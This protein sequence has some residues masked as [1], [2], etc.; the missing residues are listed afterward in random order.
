[1]FFD[2]LAS[3]TDEMLLIN[4]QHG[5]WLIRLHIPEKIPVL[6]IK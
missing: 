6:I 5:V 1:M 4:H 3:V 2:Q